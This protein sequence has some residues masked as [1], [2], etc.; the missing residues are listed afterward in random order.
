MHPIKEEQG[1]FYNLGAAN[2]LQQ[3]VGRLTRLKHNYDT[4]IAREKNEKVK[5][6]M[7]HMADAIEQC[8]SLLRSIGHT[9]YTNMEVMRD[10]VLVDVDE[11]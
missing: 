11:G 10:E 5:H 4:A 7:K 3:D 8:I 1:E 6:I 9:K 2:Q